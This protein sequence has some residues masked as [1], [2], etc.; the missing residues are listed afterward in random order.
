MSLRERVNEIRTGFERS[1]WVANFTEVFERIAYYGASAV[2][3]I[4]LSEQLHFSK[5]L[6][7]WMVGIFGFVVWFLPVL[8]GTLADR[9]GFRRALMFAYLVMTI[10]YFLLG[11]LSAPWMQGI[12]HALTDKW[13]VLAILMIPALGPAVVK[14]CVAGTTAR[15]SKDNV[16]SIGYS[17]Y[18]TLVNIGGTLGPV[19]AWLVRKPLGLGMENVFRV[20]ALSVFLMFLVTLLFFREP[21]QA[22]EQQ[23]ASVAA[24]IKNMFV[25]LANFRFVLFLI[26]WSSFFVVFWQEFV[27]AP[28]FLR[29][30]VDPNANAD[31]LL[32]VDALTVICFQILVSYLTRNIPAFSA[33]TLGL[34]I[35]SL[36]WLILAIHPSTAGFVAALVVLALGEITQSARY[37][38][39][40][41]RLAPSGQQG[42]YMGYAFLPIAIG[43]FIAGPLGGYLLHYF[44]DVLGQPQQMWWVVTGVGISGAV[45]MVVYDKV[46]KPGEA[47][48]ETRISA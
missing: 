29:G 35:S 28:L 44:G 38:E 43:Y 7:G 16:R 19:V 42:L 41:S 24:A 32:S 30:Y 36:S 48:S 40:I 23:V 11:S 20:S 33:M 1:F 3:A 17:I 6:T 27:S 37:Y 26:I 31:L 14:P 18:Y 21:K 8:G 10:G 13:L 9:F 2:L 12:R 39:Y 34:L 5:E 46:F 4:Y 45:L 25:V 15:A 22:G 47:K